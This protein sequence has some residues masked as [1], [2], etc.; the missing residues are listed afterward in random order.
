MSRHSSRGKA[1]EALRLRVLERDGWVCHYCTKQL[2]GDD[3]TADH[4][5]PKE[6]GGRDEESNLVAACRSCN[7]AKKDK[8]LIRV[9]WLNPRWLDAA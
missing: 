3:A 2:Q 5:V 4:I 9:T 7:S 8:A 6:S 1:W